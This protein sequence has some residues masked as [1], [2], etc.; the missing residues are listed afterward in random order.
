MEQRTDRQTDV[1]QRRFVHVVKGGGVKET[2]GGSSS[3]EV[4]EPEGAPLPTRRS[5]VL[6]CEPQI[7]FDI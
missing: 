3:V 7:E 1:L 2:E 4:A 5:D 6:K